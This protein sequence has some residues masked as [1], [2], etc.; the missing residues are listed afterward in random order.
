MLTYQ[1]KT[2]GAHCMTGLVLGPP[3]FGV[4]QIVQDA[5]FFIN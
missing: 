3:K 4:L 5:A 1:Q 2:H